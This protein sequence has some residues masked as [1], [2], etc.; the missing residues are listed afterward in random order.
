MNEKQDCQEDKVWVVFDDKGNKVCIVETYLA[1]DEQ[2][3]IEHYA[4]S[5]LHASLMNREDAP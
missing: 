2:E 5:W 4:D 3:A 1:D